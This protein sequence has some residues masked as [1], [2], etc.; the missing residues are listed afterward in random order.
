MGRLQPPPELPGGHHLGAP[1]ALLPAELR[2]AIPERD[3][4]QPDQS[5]ARRQA[6][7]GAREHLGLD[8][9]ARLQRRYRGGDLANA[10]HPP[11]AV[12]EADLLTRVGIVAEGELDLRQRRHA[13]GVPLRARGAVPQR[14]GRDGD[15]GEGGE[16]HRRPEQLAPHADAVED[17][18]PAPERAAAD[19]AHHAFP[20]VARFA[21][22]RWSPAKGRA[23]ATGPGGDS[24]SPFRRYDRRT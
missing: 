17:G 24:L 18:L 8:A 11:R 16:E 4:E 3:Q 22:R 14:P 15:G 13:G 19:A 7:P 2:A 23:K 1:D 20:G 12:R 10:E 21:V 6:Q 9:L 5:A